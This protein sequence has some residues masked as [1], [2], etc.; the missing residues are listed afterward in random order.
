MSE[1]RGQKTQPTSQWNKVVRWVP[2]QCTTWH[3]AC[4]SSTTGWRLGVPLLT[5]SAHRDTD[6]GVDHFQRPE[7]HWGWSRAGWGPCG[8]Q[9]TQVHK[10]EALLTQTWVGL[11]KRRWEQKQG[12]NSQL[13]SNELCSKMLKMPQ[14]LAKYSPVHFFQAGGQLDCLSARLTALSFS[15]GWA[16]QIHNVKLLAYRHWM[17]RCGVNYRC[18][19]LLGRG[20]GRVLIPGKRD[21]SSGLKRELSFNILGLYTLILQGQDL[22]DKHYSLRIIPPWSIKLSVH[23]CTFPFGLKVKWIIRKRHLHH[24]AKQENRLQSSDALSL[25][26][27]LDTV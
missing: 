9:L 2:A 7:L 18:C 22:T 20:K 5:R 8:A 13:L 15:K 16:L 25:Y 12:S 3:T 17:A 21:T 11:R 26:Q 27:V 6:G 24:Y 19:S 4:T 10:L 1:P 14:T 23:V